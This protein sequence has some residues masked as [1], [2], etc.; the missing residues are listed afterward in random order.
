VPELTT[1][2]KARD[3]GPGQRPHRGIRTALQD[4]ARAAIESGGLGALVSDDP[5]QAGGLSLVAGLGAL[6]DCRAQL[7]HNLAVDG[8]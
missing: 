4:T 8:A 1:A 7:G 2:G 5:R 3:L 6:R